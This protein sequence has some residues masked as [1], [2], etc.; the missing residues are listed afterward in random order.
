MQRP[1]VLDRSPPPNEPHRSLRVGLRRRTLF[2]GAPGGEPFRHARVPNARLAAV[3]FFN[4][5]ADALDLPALDVE[6]LDKGVLS[7]VRPGTLRRFSEL[8]EIRYDLR[9]KVQDQLGLSGHGY[10]A[11]SYRRSR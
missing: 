4:C 3:G 10:L 6:V 7:Q 1:Q 9:R 8:I 2:I 5:F 11:R